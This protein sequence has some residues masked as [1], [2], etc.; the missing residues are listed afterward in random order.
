M[1]ATQ[2]DFVNL[3]P[4]AAQTM[5]VFFLCG[6]DDASVQ[7]AAFRIASL[8]PDAGERVEFTGAELKRDPVRLGDE[9]RSTSLFGDTRHIWVRCSGDEAHDAVENLISSDVAPCPVI[10][11]AANASDK[12]RT[13][14]LLEKRD[15]ALVAMFYPPDLASVTA[16]VRQMADAAGAPMDRELAQRIAAAVGLD[17]RL[18]ASEVTKLALYLDAT[19]ER[20]RPASLEAFEAVGAKTEE[21]GFTTLVNTVLNGDS[22]R[23]KAELRRMAELELNPVGLLLAFERRVAQLAQLAGRLGTN[24]DISA[25]MEGEKASRRVFFKDVPDLSRQLR[26]WRGRPL[27]RLA[28]RLMALHRSLMVNNQTAELLLAQELAEIARYAKSRC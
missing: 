24:P 1:K 14:K 22:G 15:D 28:Q 6:T 23:L 20:P 11:Q 5:R 12:S 10:I 27:A 9:A 26:I 8:L 13:A 17:T 16:S 19:P 4:R 18:A 25:F 3:A 21:D 2:R 7:D